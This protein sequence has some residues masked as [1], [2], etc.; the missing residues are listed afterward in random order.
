MRVLLTGHKGYLGTVMAPLIRKNGHEV[1]GLDTGYFEDCVLGPQPQILPSLCRDIRD[2]TIEDL[3]G[4]DAVIHLANLCNDPLGNLD[5]Q[6]TRHINHFA[7]VRLA[8]LA[9]QAGVGRFLFA[10]SCSM[11]GAAGRDDILTEKAALCPLTPY[12]EAKVQTELELARLASDNFSPVYLRNA[13]AY[14]F[15]PRLRADLVLNNLVCWAYTTGKVKIMSDGTPWRPVVHAR[16]IALAFLCTLEAPVETIHNEAFNVGRN[17]EN[18]QVRELAQIVSQIVPNCRV[19]LAGQNNPD[20]RDYRVDFTKIQT[21]LPGF[22]PCWTAQLGAQQLYEVFEKVGL[23][24]ENF[25][26]R[27]Y[28]RLNQLTYLLKE[29]KLD[30]SLRWTRQ[31][32]LLSARGL[33]GHAIG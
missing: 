18:Y 1:V 20:P 24:L 9:R 28:I 13:T 29:S 11:Y 4:F 3:Y 31:N 14:G 23:T 30:S 19:E 7:S 2:I 6:L 27:K 33:S 22:K 15:S 5:P 21:K 25:E 26:G 16:D 10:S 32:R 17:G 12:A 8:R